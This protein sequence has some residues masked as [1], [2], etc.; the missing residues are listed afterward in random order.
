MTEAHAQ[1][2]RERL[3]LSLD[4]DGLEDLTLRVV[5]PGWPQAHV[6]RRGPDGGF[7]V[8]SDY[9]VPPER[10]WQCKNYTDNAVD[11]GKCKR[12]LKSALNGDD[13]PRHYTFVFP[14]RLN[15]TEH[16]YWR[17]TF[18][19]WAH[20]E[21]GSRL[22]TLDYWDDLADR[23]KDRPDLVNLLNDGAF[24]GYFREVMKQTAD[25]GVNPLAT[26]ADHIDDSAKAAQRAV[27][28]GKSDPHYAYGLAGR[29][30]G[31]S[32]AELPADRARFTLDRSRED[33]LPRYALSLRKGDE[34]REITAAPRE[35]SEPRPPKIW[36]SEDQVGLAARDHARG[37]LARGD[38]W[39]FRAP[40]AGS[41][42]SICQTGFAASSMKPG[43]YETVSSGS[44][45]R[46]RSR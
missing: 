43:S 28:I 29:E 15:K 18:V 26:A 4:E 3:V 20:Q 12:S 32:D 24:G 35:G 16:D 27:R 19:P 46:S 39:C 45:S 2:H 23:L 21:F 10:G 38:R 34:I 25:S 36:F 44:G 14:R 6:T 40:A 41:R 9:D 8:F 7:D 33:E 11:W 37:Q 5:L 42:L 22:P 30:A 31:I 17:K 1:R 13:S